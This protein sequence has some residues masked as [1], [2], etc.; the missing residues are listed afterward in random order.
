MKR[1][2]SLFLAMLMIASVFSICTVAA[3]DV[4][5][6]SV[7]ATYSG[8]QLDWDA[9]PGVKK[10]HIFRQDSSEDDG[11][12]VGST[13]GTSFV[14]NTVDYKATYK[15]TVVP[16][17]TNGDWGDVSFEK[18]EKITYNH[19]RVTALN[20]T[21]AGVSIKWEDVGD[22]Y[23]VFRQ[24]DP[25][26]KFAQIAVVKKASFVDEDVKYMKNYKYA[27]A[28]IDDATDGGYDNL[29]LDNP[30]DVIYNLV[31]VA[32]ST[33][34]NNGITIKWSAVDGATGYEIYRKQSTE[35]EGKLLATT[36]ELYYTDAS[37]EDGKTYSY[38][39][40]PVDGYYD[41]NVAAIDYANGVKTTQQLLKFKK[42]VSEYAGLRISWTDLST[43]TLYYLYRQT[44]KEEGGKIVYGEAE[45]I[46]AGLT[47]AE[48]F[49]KKV[50]KG[51][52]YKYSLAVQYE[53]GE[54]VPVD[55]AKLYKRATFNPPVCKSVKDTGKH[56]FSKVVID[57]EA[58]T[59][60]IGYKHYICAE[61]K[62]HSKQYAIPQVA[63]K[64]P[65]I[66]TLA[67]NANGVK[68]VWE[69]V[70]SAELYL[71]YRKVAGGKWQL[72][73]MT[74][75]NNMIDK[76]AKSGKYYS[77]SIRA[78]NKNALVSGVKVS[79]NDSSRNVLKWEKEKLTANS[80][81]IYRRDKV[82]GK[83]SYVIIDFVAN[84]NATKNKSGKYIKSYTDTTTKAS[85][86]YCVR[87]TLMS[88]RGPV[89]SLRIVATPK[90]LSVVNKE[91]G[92]LFRWNKVQGATGYRVYRKRADATGWAFLKAVKTNKYLDKRAEDG[93]DYVYTVRAVY[94][95]VYSKY[96]YNGVKIRRL[97]VPELDY[98]KSKKEG[99]EVKWNDVVG[100]ETYIVYRK[101]ANSN[102]RILGTVTDMKSVRYLDKSAKR[103]V[104]YT[105]TVRAEGADVRS[106]YDAEGVT[107]KD[108]Y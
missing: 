12:S 13:K 17:F 102:W 31:D 96:D 7:V 61:C 103:G 25:A 46:K 58:T 28:I 71:V 56:D 52:T 16:E 101:T 26:K 42:P 41:Y 90:N 33:S 77:Y 98:A 59:Y 32:S 44:G 11:A 10:Y 23:V 74:T 50:K 91:D 43:A 6:N 67:N 89:E 29:D 18:S 85:K 69:I 108:L 8:V 99:I 65:K 62:V 63:P 105:Y 51:T 4:N 1:A 14:D 47:K 66:L 73:R 57:K 97:T 75:K 5:V 24:D 68:L 38:V 107:C 19:L 82:D 78:V 9:V 80:Y 27:I 45:L 54:F 35:K 104:K 88:E 15:Y 76:T 81:L 30:L 36:T 87:N 92:I 95:D 21:Y 100:A 93:V 94:K 3:N 37:V 55:F 79:K 72:I 84:N 86:K 34:T 2:L 64:A 20:N 70:D 49:D 39:I 106:A 53:N 40:V 60:E 48:Y 83:Y 22:K